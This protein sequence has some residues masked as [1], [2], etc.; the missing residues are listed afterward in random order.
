MLIACSIFRQ[1]T[2]MLTSRILKKSE[3]WKS[4]FMLIMSEQFTVRP[5]LEQRF[6]AS[7]NRSG[8]WQLEN[9]HEL[10]IIAD[11]IVII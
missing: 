6:Q 5:A 1:K 8:S 7:V 9:N 10:Q 2:A 3:F 4:Q 11:F